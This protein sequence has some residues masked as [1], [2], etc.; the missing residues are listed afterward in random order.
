MSRKQP[1][2]N[3]VIRVGRVSA[4]FPERN[5][6]IVLFPDRDGLVS[7]ELSVGQ[8]NTLKNKDEV[9]PDPGEH[10]ICAFFGN[11]LSEGVV[12][13]SVF[14][15]K[16]NPMVGDKDRRLVIFENGAHFFHDRRQNILQIMDHFGS[17]VLFKDAD[18]IIQSKRH[19]HINPG[20]MLP[21]EI[22]PPHLGSLFD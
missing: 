17:F 7:K 2:V 3:D 19:V 8:R 9:L 22:T 6:A 18:I 14:D 12:L 11:G 16:N 1:T 13:C 5:A 15:R 4:V 20:D 21:E 10:V